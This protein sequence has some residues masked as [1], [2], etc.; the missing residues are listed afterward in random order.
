VNCREF[1]KYV[2]A[3]ADGELDTPT[4]LAALEHL[5]MCPDCAGRVTHVQGL[6]RALA[7]VFGRE[8]VPLVLAERVRDRIRSGAA[9]GEAPVAATAAESAGAMLD[10]TSRRTGRTTRRRTWLWLPLATAAAVAAAVSLWRNWPTAEPLRGAATLALGQWA[11]DVA[12]VHER[13]SAMGPR[14]HDVTIAKD[15][16]A[17]A[18]TLSDRL[19]FKVIAP[20]LTGDG[21]ELVGAEACG[22]PGRRGGH[23]L[24]RQP[25]T[26][27]WLSVFSVEPIREIERRCASSCKGVIC[28]PATRQPLH[29][30]CRGT[31]MAV[32]WSMP[33]ASYVLC[34]PRSEDELLALAAPLRARQ[35]AVADR[36]RGHVSGPVRFA[37]KTQPDPAPR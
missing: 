12:S 28:A 17:I 23:V 35:I 15:C 2:G 32:G 37:I 24:Y 30:G 27:E 33:S 6:K 18:A 31:L 34:A 21:F 36:A 29:A 13:C 4:N 10:A 16:D 25:Q 14:H 20:D 26:G 22:L 9:E 11:A 5:N 1:Q 7:R 19:G 8:P 3:F